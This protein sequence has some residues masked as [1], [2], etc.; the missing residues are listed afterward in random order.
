MPSS[1]TTAGGAQLLISRVHRAAIDKFVAAHPEPVPPSI[2]IEIWGGIEEESPDYAN[3]QYV[4]EIQQYRL[5]MGHD[6]LDLILPA[7][8]VVFNPKPVDSELLELLGVTVLD[9][10]ADLRYNILSDDVDLENVV[11]EMLYLSTVT[12][13]GMEEAQQAMAVKWMDK[14]VTAWKVPSIPVEYNP[15]FRDRKAAQ[16]CGYDWT[17]FCELTGPDQSE[18][19]AYYMLSQTLEFLSSKWR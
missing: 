3:S 9:D 6:Q 17:S 15:L 1:Y 2:M 13:Q 12:H 5:A 14:E 7:I 16:A 18:N 8:Q 4:H 10:I 19:V 11:E